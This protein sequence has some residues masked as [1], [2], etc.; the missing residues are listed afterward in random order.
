MQILFRL[1][2]DSIQILSARGLQMFYAANTHME[3]DKEGTLEGAAKKKKATLPLAAVRKLKEAILGAQ[4]M[5]PR[6][7]RSV[8][9]TRARAS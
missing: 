6:P 4:A 9:R 8:S 7:N 1:C 2:A 5:S 3:F